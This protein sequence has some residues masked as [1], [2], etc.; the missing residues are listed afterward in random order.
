MKKKRVIVK[1]LIAAIM[2]THQQN[3]LFLKVKMEGLEPPE[4]MER[5][6]GLVS[7]MEH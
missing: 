7:I 3:Q 2:L 5:E 1:I 4:R 6:M